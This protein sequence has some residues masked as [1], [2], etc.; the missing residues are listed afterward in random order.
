MGFNRE[1]RSN[2]FLVGY[3]IRILLKMKLKYRL[4]IRDNAYE[5]EVVHERDELTVSIDGKLFSY[6]ELSSDLE[7]YTLTSLKSE[8]YNINF[9]DYAFDVHLHQ[10]HEKKLIPKA[11]SNLEEYFKEG[12]LVAPMPGKIVKITCK[13]GDIVK[14]GQDLVIFEAMKMENFFTSPINGKIFKIYVK[15]NDSVSAKQILLEIRPIID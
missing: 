7:K 15:S 13:E 4:E 10:S 1:I 3:H 8:E 12:K 6:N 5:V 11:A 9:N 2:E 14:K